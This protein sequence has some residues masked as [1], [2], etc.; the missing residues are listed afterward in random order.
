MQ[1]QALGWND[2][3]VLTYGAD[4]NGRVSALRR[5]RG[6]AAAFRAWKVLRAEG[7]KGVDTFLKSMRSVA[8]LSGD[9]D[10]QRAFAA[11]ELPWCMSLVR[12]LE[13]DGQCLP[14]SVAFCAYLRT[15]GCDA[16]LVL[17]KAKFRTNPFFNFHAWVQIGAYAVNDKAST[18]A[19]HVPI[20]KSPA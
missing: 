1:R 16:Q 3:L 12:V 5:C 20:F 8:S 2:L 6:L 9:D 17:G 4:G 19:A 14:R 15:L 10:W 13:P 11:R 7:I 18:I